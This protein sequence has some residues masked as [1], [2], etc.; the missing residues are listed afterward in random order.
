MRAYHRDEGVAGGSAYGL[1]PL[2]G[3]IVMEAAD[4]RERAC[5]SIY[6]ESPCAG[7]PRAPGYGIG[8]EW[9]FSHVRVTVSRVT[10]SRVSCSVVRGACH[11]VPLLRARRGAEATARG[12]SRPVSVTADSR[13]REWRIKSIKRV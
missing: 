7:P 1:R 9:F 2:D 4:G 8:E 3:V 12:E 5:M 10:V 13:V 6:L 11:L